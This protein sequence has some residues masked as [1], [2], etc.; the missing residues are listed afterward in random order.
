MHGAGLRLRR[1]DPSLAALVRAAGG[2]DPG[3]RRSLLC[4]R[5]CENALMIP[6]YLRNPIPHR[7]ESEKI[8]SSVL[9]VRLRLPSR[10]DGQWCFAEK[11]GE[12]VRPNRQDQRLAS[13]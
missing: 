10:S 13:G 8:R 1:Q 6:L 11:G 12:T 7:P 9:L 3:L 5:R 4:L 2:L